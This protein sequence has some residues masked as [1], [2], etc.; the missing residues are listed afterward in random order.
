MIHGYSL[1]IGRMDI[2]DYEGYIKE[3]P[4]YLYCHL[5]VN[6]KNLELEKSD[7]TARYRVFASDTANADWLT[8]PESFGTEVALLK[9]NRVGVSQANFNWVEDNHSKLSFV[10]KEGEINYMTDQEDVEH[11]PLV[12]RKLEET[13]GFL[14]DGTVSVLS[15]V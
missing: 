13:F 15:R 7:E 2:D 9:P 5:L 10:L 1:K 11:Y 12:R 14:F 6:S 3:N 8:A 4:M